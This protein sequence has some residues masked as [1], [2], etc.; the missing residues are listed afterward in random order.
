MASL[1][2]KTINGNPGG[3]YSCAIQG[4]PPL[5]HSDAEIF[6]PPYLQQLDIVRPSIVSDIQTVA[7]GQPVSVYVAAGD[8]PNPTELIDFATL[9]RC[10]SVTHHFG[11]DQRCIRLEITSINAQTREITFAGLPPNDATNRGH[12]LAPPGYYMLF[13]VRKP[14]GSPLVRVPSVAR[15]VQVL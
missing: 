9:I 8:E 11:W 5:S 14:T 15:F 3:V 12:F 2:K 4:N 7:Y 13:I 6:V 1:Y 10:D